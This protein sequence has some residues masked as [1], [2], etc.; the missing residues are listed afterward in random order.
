MH[1]VDEI[2]FN[3]NQLNKNSI[4]RA[5]ANKRGGNKPF[6]VVQFKMKVDKMSNQN[7]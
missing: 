5:S 2:P 6:F 3:F 4:K 7:C 1:E